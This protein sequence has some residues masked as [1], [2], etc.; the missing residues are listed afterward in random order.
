VLHIVVVLV[1]CLTAYFSSLFRFFRFEIFFYVIVISTC[2]VGVL[3]VLTSG[4]C[5]IGIVFGIIVGFILTIQYTFG[6]LFPKFFVG[7]QLKL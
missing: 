7:F 4:G 1:V 3:F 2:I 5:T 6:F